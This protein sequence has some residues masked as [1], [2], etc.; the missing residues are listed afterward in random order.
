MKTIIGIL[1]I[2][3]FAFGAYFY[4]EKNFAK[5]EEI[6]KTMQ[7]AQAVEKRLDYKI[8]SDQVDRKE[9]RIREINKR[10]PEQSKMPETVK[11]DYDNL[12][13]EKMKLEKKM[14]VIENVK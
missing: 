11:E 5:A 12:K 3:A 2:L 1:T 9:D 14:E 8:I 10:Y 13:V 6:K 4:F 7:Y